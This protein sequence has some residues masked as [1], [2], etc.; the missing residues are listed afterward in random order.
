MS[1]LSLRLRRLPDPVRPFIAEFGRSGTLIAL[2]AFATAS[3]GAWTAPGPSLS[4][5]LGALFLALAMDLLRQRNALAEPASS[6]DAISATLD[7]L[8]LHHDSRGAVARCLVNPPELFSLP[9]E[10]LLGQGLFERVHVGDR[11]KFLKAFHDA[12]NGDGTVS[13]TIRILSGRV[14]R[15]PDGC[16]APLFDWAEMRLR[17]VRHGEAVAGPAVVSI[18]RNITDRREVAD[19]LATAQAEAMKA[20]ALKDRLLANVSHELRTPLNAILGFSEILSEDSLA[21]A[22]PEKR[23]EYARIIHS[24]AEHLLSVVNLVLDMSRIEAGKFELAPEPFALE[25]LIH[26][27]ADMLRLKCESGGVTLSCEPVEG[28]HEIVA[29]K[30]ACRQILLNLM[31][32]AIKFTPSGGVVTVAARQDRGTVQIFVTD[33]GIGIGAEDLPN[34][35]APFF[36]VR[37][38]Y[39]RSFEGAGLGL[40]LVRGLVGL[41]GGALKLESAPGAGTRVTV[42]LLADCRHPAGMGGSVSPIETIAAAPTPRAPPADRD[43]NEFTTGREKRFG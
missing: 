15:L 39:D 31:S 38:N 26:G 3:V 17:A 34:L 29:D 35:G 6:G 43:S 12:L 23:R 7:D 28:V 5:A 30:R 8:V 21:P 2:T 33:T 40:S 32:N 19:R 27:C 41:H 18:T 1:G 36:Q 24:S 20:V 11:P 37:S 42:S 14:A 16:E 9:S 4:V 13:T 10:A 22:A 25:P